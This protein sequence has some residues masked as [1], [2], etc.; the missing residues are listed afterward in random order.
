MP[1]VNDCL[2]GPDQS[3]QRLPRQVFKDPV[4]GE[5]DM[6]ESSAQGRI[7]VP[8]LPPIFRF[9]GTHLLSSYIF[10][11]NKA[12][13]VRP[14]DLRGATQLDVCSQLDSQVRLEAEICQ[15]LEWMG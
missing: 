4:T 6:V 2:S 12:R 3:K 5:I 1:F 15:I 10:Y 9:D 13:A 14:E 8:I 11:V 7:L